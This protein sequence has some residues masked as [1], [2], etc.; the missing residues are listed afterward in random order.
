MTLRRTGR[1]KEAGKMFERRTLLLEAFLKNCLAAKIDQSRPGPSAAKFCPIWASFGQILTGVGQVLSNIGQIWPDAAQIWSELGQSCPPPHPPQTRRPSAPRAPR[2]RRLNRRALVLPGKRGRGC[3]RPRAL[4]PRFR[5]QFLNASAPDSGQSLDG[6]ATMCGFSAVPA[7]E[8]KRFG[9]RFAVGTI[10][11]PKLVSC[12]LEARGSR[13]ALGVV[14]VP[15]M[16]GRPPP[17][18]LAA[19]PGLCH[20]AASAWHIEAWVAHFWGSRFI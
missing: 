6:T 15:A 9:R 19:H 4:P 1:R 3:P 18:A 5:A 17:T 13:G 11:A 12:C 8:V 16:R 10:S 20:P 7:D 14:A 2:R